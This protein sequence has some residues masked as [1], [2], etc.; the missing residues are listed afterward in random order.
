LGLWRKEGKA[1][2]DFGWGYA[3]SRFLGL[4]IKHHRVQIVPVA[5]RAR[6]WVMDREE[7]GRAKSDMPARTKDHFGHRLVCRSIGIW[8][9]GHPEERIAQDQERL[10]DDALC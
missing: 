4:I 1:E 7:A 6:F 8:A 10:D 2:V 3:Y 9:F 5:V